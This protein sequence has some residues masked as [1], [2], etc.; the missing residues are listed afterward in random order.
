MNT[1]RGFLTSILKAG[2]SSMIL[3]PAVTYARKKW[4]KGSSGL[5]VR[6]E[7]YENY[8]ILSGKIN[9][10]PGWITWEK[11]IKEVKWQPIMGDTMRGKIV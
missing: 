2:I 7:G 11:L 1:R 10:Y 5:Y 3:P 8:L 6:C 9:Y 4:V